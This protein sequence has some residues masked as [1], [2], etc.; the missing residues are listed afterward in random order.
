MSI[1]SIFAIA[2]GDDWNYFMAMAYRAQGLIA[3]FFYPFVFI[4]TNLVL[5]N[6]FLAILL[7]NFD[8]EPQDEEESESSAF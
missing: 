5:L 8:E 4:F 3:L 1:T 7:Q 6:L 2:V